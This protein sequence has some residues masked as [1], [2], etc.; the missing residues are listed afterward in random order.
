MTASER[1]PSRAVKI[2]TGCLIGLVWAM[3]LWERVTCGIAGNLWIA[4]LDLKTDALLAFAGQTVMYGL[5]MAFGVLFGVLGVEEIK[6][7]WTVVFMM[8]GLI[9]LALSTVSLFGLGLW[10]LALL[11]PGAAFGV[12]VVLQTK[13]EA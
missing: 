4:L 1:N 3:F 10:L 11:V 5:P 12:L 2:L 8:L 6:A 7:V 13:A 9:S